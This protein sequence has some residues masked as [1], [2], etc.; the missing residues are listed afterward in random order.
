MFGY[1]KPY[2]P[3]LYVEELEEYKAVYCG[4]C[5]ELGADYGL[6]FRL[7]LS[8][9]F[10]FY[11]LLA[12]AL[13]AEKPEFTKGHCALHPLRPCPK[14]KKNYA[15]SLAGAGAMILSYVKVKDDLADKGFF[16]KILALV[17]YPFAA[18]AR[19]KAL[20]L[21]P[22]EGKIIDE[23]AKAMLIKQGKV[24]KENAP[25]VDKCA[26]PTAEFLS[27]LFSLL[28]KDEER[29]AILSRLGYLLG[30]FIYFT[31]ALDDMED[32]KK[33]GNFNPF[34]VCPYEGE[35]HTYIKETIFATTAEAGAT[36]DLLTLSNFSGIIENVINQGLKNVALEI[37][38]RK[39]ATPHE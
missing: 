25:T 9:D 33:K 20:M 16:K 6:I 29:K 37:L 36:L 32:D 18:L 38:K 34:L 30:R 26:H 7:T 4:L 13:T 19:K 27:T 23:S 28:G 10:A 3:R 11:A 12:M 5:H 15:L 24:E 14:C 22:Y 21:M 39:E 17:L 2:N 31:D 35:A 8:Y 1:I